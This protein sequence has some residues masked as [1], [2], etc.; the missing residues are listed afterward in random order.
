MQNRVLVLYSNKRPGM[1]CHPARARQLL[2]AGRAAVY[3]H[4]PFTI[5]LKE[6]TDGYR[7]P[8][9]MKVDPGS[10][11][12]GMVLVA[13]FKRG[14][15]VLWAALLKH[16]GEWIKERLLSRSERRRNRRTRKL[17]YRP[18]R[19]DNRARVEGWIAPSIWSRVANIV[20]WAKR[21]QRWSPLSGFSMEQVKFD[22]QAM[23]NPEIEGVEYQQ[24]DLM[25][26]ELRE[27]LL[28][29]WG[30]KCAY[31]GVEDVP[32]QIEHI[33]PK[34]R[35]GSNRASNLTLACEPCNVSKG[36]QTAA[37]FGHPEIQ[38]KARQPLR[39]A[40]AVN[41]TRWKIF[42]ALKG[43]GLPLETGTGGRTKYNRTLQGY[44]KSHWIDAACVGKTGRH[45]FLQEDFLALTIKAM[46][47]GNRQMCSMD[48]HGFPR[49]RA[50]QHKHVRGFQTGDRVKAIVPK[51]KK[52]GT[53]VGRVTVRARGSFCVDKA[54]GISWRYCQL[55]QAVDGYS[56]TSE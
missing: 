28:E 44:P 14:L 45:V 43:L 49:T 4:Q 51:G 13:L 46:G 9:T 41:S 7:Q 12:T 55:L 3:R 18:P 19:F 10:H 25:G 26:Y 40:A 5:I 20:T 6:R 27:Y 34:T 32:L 33:N 54:D 29:K 39:D 23:Q 31:C 8:L 38:K 50:K 53:H 2:K 36:P 11:T 15:R 21:L 1:P 35:G 17:R 42:H 47:W 16:R 48:K 24:G 56:Y 37:E 52:E 30:R 22:M